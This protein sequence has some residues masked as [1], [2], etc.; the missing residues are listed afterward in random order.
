MDYEKVIKFLMPGKI[1]LILFIVLF[2]VLPALSI[3]NAGIHILWMLGGLVLLPLIG[4]ENPMSYILLILEAYLIAC[5]IVNHF[6]ASHEKYQ[7]AANLYY[8]Q[9]RRKTN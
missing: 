2:L 5:L 6:S 9:V 1:K 8:P 3:S 7:K 4:F